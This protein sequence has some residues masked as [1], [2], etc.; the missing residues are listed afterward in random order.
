MGGL[1]DPVG[2]YGMLTHLLVAAPDTAEDA[3]PREG[4]KAKGAPQND[5]QEHSLVQPSG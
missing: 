2:N 4:Q 1:G 5:S 3:E